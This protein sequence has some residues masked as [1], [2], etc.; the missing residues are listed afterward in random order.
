MLRCIPREKADIPPDDPANAST[1]SSLNR[2]HFLTSVPG[3]KARREKISCLWRAVADLLLHARM[4]T[5]RTKAMHRVTSERTENGHPYVRVAVEPNFTGIDVGD[6]A[7]VEL[8]SV[9]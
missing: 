6:A 4:V 9:D 5:E 2:A 1:R 7:D 8:S 3:E